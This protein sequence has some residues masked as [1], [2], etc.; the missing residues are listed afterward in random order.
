LASNTKKREGKITKSLRFFLDLVIII[1]VVT[2]AFGIAE[3][4]P[5]VF[6]H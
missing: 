2:I 3:P 6:H 1:I 4:S 5:W